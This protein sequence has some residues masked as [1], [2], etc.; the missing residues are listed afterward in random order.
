MNRPKIG[1][2]A[3]SLGLPLRKAV[4]AAAR[5]GADGVQVDAVGDLD[6]RQLSATGRRDFRRL[7]RSLNLE[8]CAL[9][10]PMQRGLDVA[11]GQQARIDR[12]MMTLA[13][14]F[15][16]G[17]RIVVIEAGHIP[18]D[19]KDP[20]HVLLSEALSVLGHHGDRIGAVVALET[21]LESGAQLASFLDRFDTGGLRVNFD[22]ANLMVHGFDPEQA[23]RDLRGRIAQVHAKDARR[24]GAS[25]LAQEVALGHGDIDWIALL[26]ALEESTYRG[27]LTIERDGGAD[28]VADVAAGVQ[29]LRRV[30]V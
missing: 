21:G 28:R 5:M 27:F 6:P 12:L 22:P 2:R 17:P 7:M 9:G 25:R 4:E 13:L 8:L 1:V 29:F 24:A 30:A 26:G 19:D 3:E 18:E 16:L 23:A 10:C 11:E 14:S 15:E 20:G